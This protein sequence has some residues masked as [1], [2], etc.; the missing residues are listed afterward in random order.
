MKV[1]S[2]H[3]IG[4]AS[5]MPRSAHGREPLPEKIFSRWLR[6]VIGSVILIEPPKNLDLAVLWEWAMVARS[7]AAVI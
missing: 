6:S 3:P 1:K 2:A 4:S 7:A 5:I